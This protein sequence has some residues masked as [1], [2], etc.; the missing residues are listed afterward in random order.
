MKVG[1][2]KLCG[3]QAELV[4]SHIWSRFG[5]KRYASDSSKGGQFVDLGKRKTHNKQYTKEWICTACEARLG[6]AEDYTARLLTRLEAQR[7]APQEYDD[8]LL[9]FVTSMSWRTALYDLD[10]HPDHADKHAR[11]Q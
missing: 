3:K 5:Y 8:R 7:D 10:R 1:Q 9:K 4:R 2:C 11:G 6:E